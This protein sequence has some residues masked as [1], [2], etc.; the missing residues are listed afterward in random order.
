MAGNMSR[1]TTLHC[2]HAMVHCSAM[3]TWYTTI[4]SCSPACVR[5]T[6]RLRMAAQ[7]A[8]PIPRHAH[9]AYIT[10]RMKNQ[11]LKPALSVFVIVVVMRILAVASPNVLKQ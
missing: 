10:D 11:S 4:H 7:Q 9:H 6:A 1:Y 8:R 5:S 3:C 2:V